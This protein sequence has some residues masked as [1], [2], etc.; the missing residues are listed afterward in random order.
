[1]RSLVG[2]GADGTRLSSGDH[3]ADLSTAQVLVPY[4]GSKTARAALDEAAECAIALGASAWVLYV[5]P[6]D[7]SRGGHYFV[8]TP[9]EA[10][11]VAAE[12][13]WRLR[14]RGVSASSVMRS[15]DRL[16]VPH[17]I[18]AE[19]DTLDVR[20]I[21]LGTRTRSAVSTALLGST[22]GSVARRATRPVVLVQATSSTA[23][24]A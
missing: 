24:L 7:T 3:D 15:A 4:N 9:A 5:R 14:A 20:M 18:L 17:A 12:A 22:S 6:W 1:M 11:A 10:R 16:R 19:A 23:A 8:E 2:H 21:V 13:V